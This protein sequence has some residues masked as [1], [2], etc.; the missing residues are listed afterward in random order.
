VF[1]SGVAY[2][3]GVVGRLVASLAFCSGR[4]WTTRSLVAFRLALAS[5]DDFSR[6][7]IYPPSVVPAA[8]GPKEGGQGKL[9]GEGRGE[10]DTY[11][12]IEVGSGQVSG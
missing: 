6:A 7:T 4:R 11:E 12:R 5:S 2:S 1:G 8:F 9:A 10:G 3:S